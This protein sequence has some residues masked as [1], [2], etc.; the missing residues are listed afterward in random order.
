MSKKVLPTLT[1]NG[2][3]SDVDEMLN[4]IYYYYIT[5]DYTQS[6]TFF[7]EIKSLAYALK[8]ADFKPDRATEEVKYDL[9]NI[10][11]RYF[12]HS[13]VSSLT[14]DYKEELTGNNKVIYVIGID[15]EVIDKTGKKYQLS[16][17]I[18]LDENNKLHFNDGIDY[19]MYFAENKK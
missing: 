5:S 12:E 16:K 4:R 1:H 2:F 11:H 13:D 14:V 15:I 9:I 19:L 17:S 8:R 3:I 18:K 10:L 6:I 7:G